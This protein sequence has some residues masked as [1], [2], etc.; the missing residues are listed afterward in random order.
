MGITVLSVFEIFNCIF[1]CDGLDWKK[2]IEIV[3]SN[4]LLKAG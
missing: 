3:K 4:S 1:T 2:I